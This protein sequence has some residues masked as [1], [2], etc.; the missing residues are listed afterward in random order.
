VYFALLFGFIISELKINLRIYITISQVRKTR[1]GNVTSQTIKKQFDEK[2]IKAVRIS[3]LVPVLFF[4]FH[5]VRF[6][7]SLSNFHRQKFSSIVR[8]NC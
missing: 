3:I 7:G 1:R 4:M 5:S 2:M 8:S 6:L